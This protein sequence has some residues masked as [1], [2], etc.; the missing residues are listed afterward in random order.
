MSKKLNNVSIILKGSDVYTVVLNNIEYANSCTK[1]LNINLEDQ[2]TWVKYSCINVESVPGEL[3]KDNLV[4]IIR[5]YDNDIISVHI[6]DAI[7]AQVT[8]GSL[9]EDKNEDDGVYKIGHLD[10]FK[11]N[12]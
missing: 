6:N 8:Y 12:N 7:K 1:A 9:L 4:S 5:R 2:E 10:T 11:F 3:K